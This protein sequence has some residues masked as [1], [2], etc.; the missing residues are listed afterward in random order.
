M[1]SSFESNTNVDVRGEFKTVDVEEANRLPSYEEA[2]NALDSTRLPGY[3][4]ISSARYH[5]Y[6]RP[7]LKVVNENDR[8]FVSPYH[9]LPTF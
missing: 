2:M 7:V 4:A 9:K 1:P 3:R 8:F 6:Q 5:P